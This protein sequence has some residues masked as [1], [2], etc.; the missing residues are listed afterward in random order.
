MFLPDKKKTATVILAKMKP[1]GSQTR[2]AVKPEVSLNE[3]DEV[4]KSIAEDLHYAIKNDSIQGIVEAM[5]AFW[6]QIQLKDVEQDK[7]LG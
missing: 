3:G 6:D 7:D 1:D 5:K 2:Q 4:L